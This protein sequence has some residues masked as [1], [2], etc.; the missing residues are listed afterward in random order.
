MIIRFIDEDL[1]IRGNRIMVELIQ[2]KIMDE[3]FETIVPTKEMKKAYF[4]GITS[5]SKEYGKNIITKAE[6]G[7]PNQFDSIADPTTEVYEV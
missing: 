4:I 1:W 3:H 7:I 2:N 6:W 5:V